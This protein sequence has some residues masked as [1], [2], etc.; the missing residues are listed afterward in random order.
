MLA[1]VPRFMQ[2]TQI[3]HSRI[4]MD[5]ARRVRVVV[6]EGTQVVH[7]DG[8]T[9]ALDATDLEFEIIPRALRVVC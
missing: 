5:R 6:K 2:G 1:L 7:A 4:H 9:I 8:E 3:G